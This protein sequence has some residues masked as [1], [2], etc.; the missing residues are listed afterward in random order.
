[1][2]YVVFVVTAALR[3]PRSDARLRCVVW[4]SDWAKERQ[5]CCRVC[6]QVE[7]VIYS[8][9]FHRAGLLRVSRVARSRSRIVHVLGQCLYS[10]DR[11]TC[12]SASDVR[13]HLA[14]KH[15]FSLG[16]EVIIEI[17]EFS[18]AGSVLVD[19]GRHGADSN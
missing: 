3:P 1:M 5:S 9:L 8:M 10:I 11:A 4:A 18:H 2:V 13:S 15:S 17:I 12:A 7:I 6:P 14:Q 19:A 16:R